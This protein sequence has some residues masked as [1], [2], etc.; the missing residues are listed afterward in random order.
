MKIISITVNV[1]ASDKVWKK[2]TD[3]KMEE[4][5]EITQEIADSLVEILKERLLNEKLTVTCQLS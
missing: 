4:I 1:E 2:L 5:S 3:E